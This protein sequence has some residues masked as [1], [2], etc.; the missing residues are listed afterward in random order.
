[1]TIRGAAQQG[2]RC[3]CARAA[4][5][6]AVSRQSNLAKGEPRQRAHIG[7]SGGCCRRTRAADSRARRA[8]R[9]LHLRSVGGV[10]SHE[11][12]QRD[13]RGARRE[14][15]AAIPA[16]TRGTGQVDAVRR[17]PDSKGRSGRSRCAWCRRSAPGRDRATAQHVARGIVPRNSGLAALCAPAPGRRSAGARGRPTRN[18]GCGGNGS[19]ASHSVQA[20]AS[21]LTLESDHPWKAKSPSPYN[22]GPCL[23]SLAALSPLDGRYA[24]P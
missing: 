3:S 11:Q 19:E 24:G 10:A 4:Q 21:A 8:R 13:L 7:E 18:T 14:S 6:G 22:R 1:M 16:R 23:S 12:G 2:R 20:R 17:C 9:L 5:E 15:A